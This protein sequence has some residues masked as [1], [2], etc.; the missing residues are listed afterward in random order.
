MTAGKGVNAKES[1]RARFSSY[2]RQEEFLQHIADRLGR[3]RQTEAPQHPYRGVPDYWRE[4]TLDR[5]ARIELFMKNWTDLGGHALRLAD[6]KDVRQFLQEFVQ[7]TGAQRVL[8]QDQPELKELDLAQ[9]FDGAGGAEVAVWD[10]A[11]SDL[12]GSAAQA[13]IGIALVDHAAAYTG[14][15]VVQSSPQ[16]GRSTSLLPKVFIAVI[17]AAVIEP[18]L[19]PILRSLDALPKEE[20][21]A[22]VH[23]ITGPSRSSDI[24]NDLTIGVHGPGI[25]YAVV[26]G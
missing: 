14:T 24:E 3:P 15:V 8:V 21:P 2:E 10:S 22:G 9:A 18:N 16:K 6:M 11:A 13:D 5:E 4:Y 20:L 25:V 23:F 26:V 7:E 19:G 12:L 1:A 17:P